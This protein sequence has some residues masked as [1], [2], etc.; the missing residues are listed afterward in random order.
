MEVLGADGK[1]KSVKVVKNKLVENQDGTV[2]PVASEE[3]ENIPAGLI[4]EVSA[5]KVNPC[6]IFPMMKTQ[7]Q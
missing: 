2:R 6:L 7:A 5:T 1:V 4:L 3:T